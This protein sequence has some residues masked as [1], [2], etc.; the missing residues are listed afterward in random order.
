M[1]AR[2]QIQTNRSEAQF[3]LKDV[4]NDPFMLHQANLLVAQTYKGFTDG[5]LDLDDVYQEL[6]VSDYLNKGLARTLALYGEH[7]I[8]GVE[9]ML[10]TIRIMMADESKDT[11]D[12]LEIKE[13]LEIEGGW[14]KFTFE[15]FNEHQAIEFGRLC[16]AFPFANGKLKEKGFYLD[17]IRNLVA[18]AFSLS[19]TKYGKDQAWAIMRDHVA[20]AVMKS[21]IEVIK[22]PDVGIK[23]DGNREI[24]TRYQRYWVLNKI[25]FYKILPD[26]CP[27]VSFS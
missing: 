1:L 19:K 15:G 21:G 5:S 8:T 20:R 17:I 2:D 13:I 22:V 18:G 25:G 9:Q 3:V 11:A 16:I 26:E 12:N 4:T 14:D 7:P 24:F 6:C 27:N 23:L 10:G